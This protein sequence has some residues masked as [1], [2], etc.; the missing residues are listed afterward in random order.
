MLTHTHTVLHLCVCAD[1]WAL[2]ADGEQMFSTH[3]STEEEEGEE[4]RKIKGGEKE[5]EM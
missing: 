3:P 2:G 5:E 1:I 4:E